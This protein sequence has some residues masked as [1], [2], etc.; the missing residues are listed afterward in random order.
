[1]LDRDMDV[2]Y[3]YHILT[4]TPT[5]NNIMEQYQLDLIKLD[6]ASKG[7]TVYSTSKGNGNVWV[8]YGRSIECYYFFAN[9]AIS[10]IVFD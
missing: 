9:N 10:Q 2:P 8:S 5:R 3:N 4:A 7:I 1:M 6:L